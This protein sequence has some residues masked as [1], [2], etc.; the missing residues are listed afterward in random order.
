MVGTS[1]C[2]NDLSNIFMLAIESPG[3]KSKPNTN[4][5]D[6]IIELPLL[7]TKVPGLTCWLYKFFINCIAPFS[8]I[9]LPFLT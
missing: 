1:D 4:L 2:D 7:S 9:I 3:T 5:V 8:F 6:I